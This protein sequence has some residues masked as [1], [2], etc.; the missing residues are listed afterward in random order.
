MCRQAR[1]LGHEVSFKGSESNWILEPQL[2]PNEAKLGFVAQSKRLF[3]IHQKVLF[4]FESVIDF[5]AVF[6]SGS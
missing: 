3:G 5:V 2:N 4:T 1:G 6:V